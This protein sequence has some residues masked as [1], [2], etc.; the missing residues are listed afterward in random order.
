MNVIMKLL[1]SKDSLNNNWS[2]ILKSNMS[3]IH[4]SQTK[5][6]CIIDMSDKSG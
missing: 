5:Q 3:L 2:I 4:K 6:H 1:K